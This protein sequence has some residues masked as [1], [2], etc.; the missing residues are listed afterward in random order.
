MYIGVVVTKN[1]DIFHGVN[2]W[3]VSQRNISTIWLYSAIHVG[4]YDATEDKSKTDT[5]QK[6]NTTQKKQTTQNKA[7][8]NYP[9]GSLASYNTRPGKVGLFY[10]APEP[11]GALVCWHFGRRKYKPQ[12]RKYTT[13]IG[14][15]WA[16]F[17]VSTNTV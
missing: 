1:N 3:A 15:D 12:I 10:N 6:L 14:L 7:K 5:R 4:I 11:T 16:V 13:T 17:N 2:E 8:Q 9:D